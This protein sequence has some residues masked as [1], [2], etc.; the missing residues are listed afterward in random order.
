VAWAEYRRKRSHLSFG[1]GIRLDCLFPQSSAQIL[2]RNPIRQA[3]GAF[4]IGRSDRDRYQ[5]RTRIVGYCDLLHEACHGKIARRR[6]GQ[7]ENRPNRRQR[8]RQKRQARIGRIIVEPENR[9]DC[10]GGPARSDDAGHAIHDGGRVDGGSRLDLLTRNSF[11][12]DEIE[13]DHG[14]AG[15]ARRD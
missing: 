14:F 9:N 15:I 3:G 1:H 5:I 6:R 12:A 4:R 10:A 11:L 2:G 8:P 13:L 7:P